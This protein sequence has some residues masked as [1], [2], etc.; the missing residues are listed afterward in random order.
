M[1][2][3]G[4]EKSFALKTQKRGFAPLGGGVVLVHQGIVKNGLPAIQ[5]VEEGKVKRVRGL[6]ASSKVSP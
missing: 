3:F 5:L 4:L 6:L 1:E 2:T